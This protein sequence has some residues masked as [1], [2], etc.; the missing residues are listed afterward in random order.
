MGYFGMASKIT[1]PSNL[2]FSLLGICQNK[3]WEVPQPHQ[4]TTV[5]QFSAT[6]VPESNN[7]SAILIPNTFDGMVK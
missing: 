1:R 4:P 5:E 2:G 7:I 3:I 6:I